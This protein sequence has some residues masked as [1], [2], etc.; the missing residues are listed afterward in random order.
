V[1]DAKIGIIATKKEQK[2]MTINGPT[3]TDRTCGGKLAG[4][5]AK[6]GIPEAQIIISRLI[7]QEFERLLLVKPMYCQCT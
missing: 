5:I 3:E 6:W 1:E 7:A 4:N 2:T